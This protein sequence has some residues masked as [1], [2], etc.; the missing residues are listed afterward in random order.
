MKRTLFL[1]LGGTGGKTLEILFDRMSDSEKLTA[2]YIYMDTDSRDTNIA[3]AEGIKTIQISNADNVLQVANALGVETDGVKEWLPMSKN[4]SEF[5]S[6][7]LHNGASQCRMKSRLCLAR[8]LKDN[9]SEFND[10]LE[11]MTP[12]G[13]ETER[14]PI[15]VVIVSSVAGG[16]GAG[17]FIQ[18]ALHVRKFFRNLGQDATIIGVLSLP[19]IYKNVVKLE[20]ERKSLFANAYAAIRELNAMNLATVPGKNLP[21]K[22]KD[23]LLQRIQ[24]YGEKI[25]IKIDT[26]SEGT[27]FNSQKPEFTLDTTTKPF[28]LI[29]FVD[30]ANEKGGIMRDIKDYYRVMANIAYTRL[31]SPMNTVIEGGESNELRVHAAVPTAIYGGAG[32]AKIV[33]PYE[34]ILKYIAEAHVLG[35][36]DARWTYFDDLWQNECDQERSLAYAQ[37]EAWVPETG[38]RGIKFRE[39]LDTELRKE[40]SLFEFLRK[41]V[42][43]NGSSRVKSYLDTVAEQATSI[44]AGRSLPTSVGEIRRISKPYS[45]LKNAK[46]A[47]ELGRLSKNCAVSNDDGNGFDSILSICSQVKSSWPGLRDLFC[48]AVKSAAY[49]LALS[50][51]PTT[52]DSAK[53]NDIPKNSVS[54][55]YGLLAI[56]H[57]GSRIDIHPLAARYLLYGLQETCPKSSM[58]ITTEVSKSFDR[59]LRNITLTFDDDQGDDYDVDVSE[60]VNFNRDRIMFPKKKDALGNDMLSDFA[61]NVLANLTNLVRE[62]DQII[63][64]MALKLVAPHVSNLVR[65]YENFFEIIPEYKGTLTRQLQHDAH[66]HEDAGNHLVFVSAS[67]SVKRHYAMLPAVRAALE[68]DPHRNYACAGS[69]LYKT[70][71]DKVI[72]GNDTQLVASMIREAGK[73]NSYDPGE[74]FDQIIN[75]YRCQLDTHGTILKTNVIGAINN[76]ILVELGITQEEL[77]GNVAMTQRYRE[78]FKEILKNL[79]AKSR[80]MVRYNEQN[81]HKYYLEETK[82]TRLDVS[83][84]YCYFGIGP[85]ARKSLI[86]IFSSEATTGTMAEFESLMDLSAGS[87]CTH[88]SYNDRELFCFS[89]V[90]CLQPT[91]IYHFTE[92]TNEESY[93]PCY[94]ERVSSSLR[95]DSPHLDIRWN[96]RGCMPY[97][98]PELELEW[99]TQTIKALIYEALFGY[100][101]FEVP[102]NKKT[103]QKLFIREEGKGVAVRPCWPVN[104]PIQVRNI[105]R[106]VEYLADDEAT[107]LRRSHE[108]DVQI[109]RFIS[110][111]SN[112]T[113]NPGLYKQGM[114]KDLLLYYLRNCFINNVSEDCDVDPELIDEYVADSSKTLGGVL[115]V[116]YLMHKSEEY[117]GEDKD[118][119]ELLLDTVLDIVYRYSVNL[120]GASQT[121]N[122]SEL[123]EE[124]EDV[125]QWALDK[126]V[127]DWVKGTTLGKVQET[128]TA[129][130]APAKK[131]RGLAPIPEGNLPEGNKID[132]PRKLSNTDEYRWIKANWVRKDR[133]K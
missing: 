125:F 26:K 71:S 60:A 12:P 47:S 10:M 122:N 67:E 116:A 129:D 114:T 24:G 14:D 37:G 121:A 112:Y 82:D 45:I 95:L 73:N 86:D 13:L 41:S 72:E 107:I 128:H 64:N 70:L 25:N 104:E 108:L 69:A 16:T 65:E 101:T 87:V 78:C 110:N 117:L 77:V 21:G 105:S 19:D 83:K 40:N 109:S 30:K 66:S 38:R 55:H 75:E 2:K 90:H 15:R 1:G 35:E 100:I 18:L 42:Y 130:E 102:K 94:K 20:A 36:L 6:S 124:M 46:I 132:I 39:D 92:N 33:Y 23:T 68:S 91:Q 31:Y 34:D 98:S 74:V 11:S 120:H 97:I 113:G 48:D 123:A 27:L 88:R 44:G 58:D 22:K 111:L 57:E 51:F 126:F 99:R 43:Q 85:K 49:G 133:H 80:P 52:A 89:S 63:V 81:L 127:E 32:Y 56:D 76:E 118:Y 54:L 8:Y 131:R 50:M 59:I 93:Y 17:T 7:P 61:D 96:R 29:Y 53:F 115:H 119:G 4:D 5:L 3:R 62:A 84:T 103:T 28:D 106:L 9:A 79:T